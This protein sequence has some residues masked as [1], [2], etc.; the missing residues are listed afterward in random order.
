MELH[1]WSIALV[2]QRGFVKK[3]FTL[4]DSLTWISSEL[5][6]PSSG[7]CPKSQNPGCEGPNSSG[8]ASPAEQLGTRFLE[9]E[10]RVNST[11]LPMEVVNHQEYN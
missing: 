1:S 8:S 9:R 3:A 2:S 11:G 5:W 7:T 6:A 10:D 4:L